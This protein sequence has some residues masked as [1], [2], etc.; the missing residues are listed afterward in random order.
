MAYC[1]GDKKRL[2][3]DSAVSLT[4]TSDSSQLPFIP[5]LGIQRALGLP[6]APK[7][8]TE[9]FLNDYTTPQNKENKTKHIIS[10]AR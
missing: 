2:G 7:K 1:K 6:W 10:S 3:A 5:A 4:P 8:G 9:Y